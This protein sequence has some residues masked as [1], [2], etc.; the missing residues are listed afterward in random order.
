MRSA[1]LASASYCSL[2]TARDTSRRRARDTSSSATLATSRRSKRRVYSPTAASPR[3]RTSATMSRTVVSILGSIARARSSSRSKS[4]AN[5]LARVFSRRSLS[6]LMGDSSDGLLQ[7]ADEILQCLV[8]HFH[9]G[10]VGH[11]PGADIGDVLDLDQAVGLQR[12]TGIDQ[13]DNAV[14]KTHERGELHRAV[15]LDDIGLNALGGEVPL[16]GF[17]VF[18]CDAQPCPAARIVARGQARRLGHP[19]AAA[20]DPEGPG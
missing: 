4:A 16:R 8:F 14:G 10:L 20:G 18:G 13:V 1:A 12:I 9:R 17:D 2:V 5:P 11:E 7:P 6:V 19:H 15:E 3:A